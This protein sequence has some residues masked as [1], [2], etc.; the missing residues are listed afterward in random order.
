MGILKQLCKEQKISLRVLSE[1]SGVS[2]AE[3]AK[4]NQDSE[5]LIN[6][7]TADKLDQGWRKL[8]GEPLPPYKYLTILTQKQND[9]SNQ[10][11]GI[12]FENAD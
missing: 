5:R 1:A 8:F 4:I 9:K 11:H 12:I 3:I 6:V 10:D 7:L 2:Y